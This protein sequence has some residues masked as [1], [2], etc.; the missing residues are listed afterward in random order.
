MESKPTEAGGIQATKDDSYQQDGFEQD[1]VTAQSTDESVIDA[2]IKELANSDIEFVHIESENIIQKAEDSIKIIKEGQD[3]GFWI[4]LWKSNLKVR[5]V[6][7]AVVLLEHYDKILKKG[8]DFMKWL[9]D[10]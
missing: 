7:C 6:K 4:R 2:S 5:S 1:D 3:A 10:G 9:M 8:C